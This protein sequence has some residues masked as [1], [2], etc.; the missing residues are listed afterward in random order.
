[1]IQVIRLLA[2][3]R[4]DPNS[5]LRNDLLEIILHILMNSDSNTQVQS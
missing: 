1:M 3:E 5:S 2:N 4:F